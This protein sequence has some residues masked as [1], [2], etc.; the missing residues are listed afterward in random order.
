MLALGDLDGDGDLDIFDA[1]I[2][3]MSA[4]RKRRGGRAAE[5]SLAERW[6]GQFQ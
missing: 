3:S 2:T 6:Q 1:N 4:R 5:S